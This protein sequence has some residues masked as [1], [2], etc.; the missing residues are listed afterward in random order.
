M[1]AR[2]V[3]VATPW[4]APAKLRDVDDALERVDDPPVD[5]EVDVDRGVVLGDRRLARDLDELLADVDLDR[6]IDDRDEEP[7]ARVADHRLVR[8]AQPEDDHLLVLLDDPDRE[9][10]DDQQDDARR[11]RRSARSG[12]FHGSSFRRRW[13]AGGSAAAVM[14]VR[15]DDE[16]SGRRCA[17]TRT[18]VPR[19]SGALVGASGPTTPRRRRRPSPSGS[20][21]RRTWPSVP[22]ATTG[23]AAQP[24]RPSRAGPDGGERDQRTER[25]GRRRHRRRGAARRRGRPARTGPAWV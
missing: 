14:R 15:L 9:V 20:S 4:S 13:L 16:R 11:T 12:D 19:G 25:G 22:D 8:L 21:G 23:A 6:P 10:H 1:T 17:T 2:S 24:G 18:G 7:Q 3:V 5:Q